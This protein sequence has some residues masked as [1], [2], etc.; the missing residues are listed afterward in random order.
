[1]TFSY[2]LC[3]FE[4]YLV[5][6]L[7]GFAY[8]VTISDGNNA[9]TVAGPFQTAFLKFQAI[10]GLN[11]H[12]YKLTFLIDEILISLTYSWSHHMC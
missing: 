10:G 3:Y 8:H 1:M 7:E 11:N 12:Y 9:Q 2:T 6:A 4:V 5:F